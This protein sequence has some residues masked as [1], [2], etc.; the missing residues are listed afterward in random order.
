MHLHWHTLSH[1][2][3]L[4]EIDIGNDEARSRFACHGAMRPYTIVPSGISE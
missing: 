4:I 2:F 3:N 1:F